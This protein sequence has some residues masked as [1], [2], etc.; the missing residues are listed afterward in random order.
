M[1]QRHVQGGRMTE[2]IKV[3]IYLKLPELSPTKIMAWNCNVDD[4]AK[5]R[6]DMILGIVLLSVLGLNIKLLDH[7]IEENDGPVKASNAPMVDMGTYEFKDLNTGKITTEEFL[8]MFMQN[9]YMNRNKDVLL[10][11]ILV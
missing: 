3:T 1:I 6:Y 2:N 5:G 4:S 8:Q 7:F 9:K 11:N 10:I